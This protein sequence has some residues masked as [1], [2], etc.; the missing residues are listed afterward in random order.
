MILSSGYGLIHALSTSICRCGGNGHW[1]FKKYIL[2]ANFTNKGWTICLAHLIWLAVHVSVHLA[3]SANA[4]TDGQTNTQRSSGI[5]RSFVL[6]VRRRR[7]CWSVQRRSR[8]VLRRRERNYKCEK[9]LCLRL[10]LHTNGR[11]CVLA[12]AHRQESK[13]ATGKNSSAFSLPSLLPS[14]CLCL[15]AGRRHRAARIREL[16]A[17]SMG[18]A[19]NFIPVCA[20]K[21]IRSALIA[22]IDPHYGLFVFSIKTHIPSRPFLRVGFLQLE[23]MKVKTD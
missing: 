3:F 5:V 1:L 7:H 17:N 10:S 12:H 16:H 13:R 19:A 6:L 21:R 18:E 22:A 4:L 20:V 14:T 2:Y 11:A 15:R 8:R 9:L 23:D